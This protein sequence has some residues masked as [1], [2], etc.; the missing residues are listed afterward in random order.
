VNRTGDEDAED[1]DEEEDDKRV[2]SELE[3]VLQKKQENNYN[4]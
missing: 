4:N 3:Y 1:D 2:I